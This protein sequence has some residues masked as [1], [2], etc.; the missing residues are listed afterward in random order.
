MSAERDWIDISQALLTPAIAVAGLGLA[1][2][3]WKLSEA[4]HRRELFQRRFAVFE[5][6]RDFVSKTLSQ[7][8]STPEMQ[9][10]FFGVFR[11]V[12]G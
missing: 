3:Q 9:L 4:G 7:G 11:K 8:R 5:A 6:V 12:S 1:Y 2:V 10:A